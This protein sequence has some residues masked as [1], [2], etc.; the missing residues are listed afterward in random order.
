MTLGLA[1]HMMPLG[2]VQGQDTSTDMGQSVE[3]TVA[4]TGA[5]MSTLSGA[6][7]QVACTPACQAKIDGVRTSC[8]N[9]KYD[10]TDPITGMIAER[11]FMQKS[12]Q[13]LQLMGPDDCDYRAG[14][15]NC[16]NEACSMANITGGDATTKY[17]QHGCITV[18]PTTSQSAPMAA[19]H[20]CEGVC[21]A[22]F[23]Q[24]VHGCSGCQDPVLRN[25]MA[26][27]GRK[28][29]VCA[30]GNRQSCSRLKESLNSACCA[31]PGGVV[32]DG[33]DTCNIKLG[34]MTTSCPKN[35][36]CAAALQSAG[37]TC[38]HQFTTDHKMLGLFLDC[39]GN[40]QQLFAAEPVTTKTAVYCHATN[41]QGIAMPGS[42]DNG[43]RRR[44]T[45]AS[46]AEHRAEEILAFFREHAVEEL[47]EEDDA[48]EAEVA[49]VHRALQGLD[50]GAVDDP[51][52]SKSYQEAFDAALQGDCSHHTCTAACQTIISNMLAACKGQY[53]THTD[54]ATNMTVT[55][56]FTSKAVTAL[57]LL[58][59]ADCAYHAGFQSC[60][61]K[62]NIV[63]AT[64]ELNGLAPG[65]T[66]N[67]PECAVFFMGVDFHEWTGCGTPSTVPGG[68]WNDV[69]QAVKDRCWARYVDYVESCSGCTDPFIQQFLQKTARATANTHCENC[70]RPQEIANKIRQMCCAGA[71]GISG[72]DDDPC[73][74]QV[75][76]NTDSGAGG[77]AGNT[78]DISW[79][80]PD[81]C[82]EDS[83]CEA[84]ILEIANNSCPSLFI[85]GAD[86]DAT[87]GGVGLTIYTACGGD[88]KGLLSHGASCLAPQVGPEH[89]PEPLAS[90]GTCNSTYL[91]SGSSCEMTCPTGY[92]I[93]GRQ[94][95]CYDG[96]LINT[97][98]CQTQ[99]VQ[100]C[101]FPPNGGCD[102][103][104]ICSD[105]TNLYGTKLVQCSQCPSGF[106]GSGRSGCYDINE[107][108]VVRLNS[109]C[110]LATLFLIQL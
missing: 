47:D 84:Y 82:E 35:P 44:L 88:V 105:A 16:D 68:P 10:T 46:D 45:D 34:N 5:Y 98:Q 53:F 96:H 51:A 28:L 14:Y 33:D 87:R 70:D 101:Q 12:I 81:T 41:G 94:P 90:L 21:R 11:S 106:Y 20:S 63:N 32:G 59:P 58:G 89:S 17:E 104:T 77:T 71:D 109:T 29:V 80:I 30:T 83:A 107:C 85:S 73:T 39:G 18:D 76:K 61:D 24:L 74:Q 100:T 50:P 86:S 56:M 95:Q 91:R 25:F 108:T 23:E 43:G 36:V 65:E 9:Q 52:C 102:P 49:P 75:E 66:T 54:K 13:A 48:V 40:M 67:D 64:R 1:V 78:H 15:E 93:S 69:A 27:A 99:S 26:D 38:P 3:C 92:C 37:V 97:M 2:L 60:S 72:N 31:G 110:S 22:E 4:Y 42:Y 55:H 19:W 7:S 62:C 79:Y 57:R 6:C 8:I 103:H